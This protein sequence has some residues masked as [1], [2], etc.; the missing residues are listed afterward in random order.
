MDTAQHDKDTLNSNV[1][2]RDVQLNSGWN[3][4]DDIILKEW[5]DKS[6]CLH[7][8]HERS[9]KRYKR[10]YLRQM[11]PVIIISTLTG[12]ANFAIERLSTTQQKYASLIIGGFNIIAGIVS[13]ISQFLKT[14]E[15]KEG[16]KIAS[17]S[18]DKFNRGLKI[19]LQRRP[20]ERTD[21]KELFTYSLK[22][23]DR[24]VELSPD[25][26]S[27][28]IKDFR[29]EYK[30]VD[31]LVKPE[32]ADKILSS[33]VYLTEDEYSQPPVQIMQEEP[34]QVAKDDFINKF[35]CKYGRRPTEKE[36]DEYMDLRSIESVL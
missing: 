11:I 12:A 26:P 28:V 7:W 9:Y 17:K 36:V 30:T 31:D 21:K 8:L 25:I 24:L 1:D 5:V 33:K 32:I 29:Y 13:T 15:L 6:S 27:A 19:E 35:V 2:I 22:E 34:E 4:D 18:W 20:T 23:F 16:H 14:S 3:P 10:Q